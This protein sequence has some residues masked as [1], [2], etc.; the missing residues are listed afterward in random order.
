LGS[1]LG[2]GLKGD[3]NVANQYGKYSNELTLPEMTIV[4]AVEL[5][6]TGD[7]SFT[8]EDLVVRVWQKYPQRTGLR[9][10]E[11]T[12]PDSN[13][14]LAGVMGAKGLEQK[15]WLLRVVARTYRTTLAGRRV[16]AQLLGKE[17]PE[18][19]EEHQVRLDADET[20]F[21]VRLRATEAR[22]KYERGSLTELSFADAC[23]FWLVNEQMTKAELDR[24]IDDVTKALRNLY[25]K[26]ADGDAVTKQGEVVTAE[27]L[28]FLTN[29]HT[30]MLDRFERHLNL[31][32]NRIRPARKAVAL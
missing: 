15:G 9:G 17:V 10:Y 28:R 32:R 11:T 26:L 24:T 13:R 20:S 16:A 30:N 6:P 19:D 31:L 23:H 7:V 25:V 14:I 3:A 22:A 21:L 27:N 8:A 12:H 1:E 2:Q 5:C 18:A 29:V 4:A